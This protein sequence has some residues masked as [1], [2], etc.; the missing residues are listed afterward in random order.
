MGEAAA[1]ELAHARTP[2]R[3]GRYGWVA[4][5][6]SWVVCGTAPTPAQAER[7]V[8]IEF[9]D[10][11]ERRKTMSTTVV[12]EQAAPAIPAAK[13][14]ERYLQVRDKKEAL[15]KAQKEQLK[16]YDALLD[17]IE[18]M[19]LEQLN[20]GEANSVNTE[21]G[22]AYKTT[23]TSATVDDWT[24]VL[25]YIRE[26]DAWELLDARVNKTAVVEIMGELAKEADA[27][28]AQGLQVDPSMLV[29][30][31]VKLSSIISVNVRRS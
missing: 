30:P 22:T 21:S 13:L 18:G 1:I 9:T 11:M 8:I 27:A 2:D 4:H 23:K 5:G 14:I 26:F 31:G 29:I 20:A 28:V 24:K 15:V 25:G 6:P 7:S 17:K 3:N 10:Y 16:P 19:L 12:A